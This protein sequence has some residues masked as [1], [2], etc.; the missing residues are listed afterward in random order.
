[1]EPPKPP[2][3]TSWLTTES[4]GRPPPPRLVTVA[5]R[6][7]FVIVAVTTVVCAIGLAFRVAR[8]ACGF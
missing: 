5:L 4:V 6:V 1:M 7:A 8:L 3:D 2:P